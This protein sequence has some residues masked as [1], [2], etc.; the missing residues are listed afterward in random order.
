[1]C[2]ASLTESALVRRFFAA[3]DVEYEWDGEGASSS[4]AVS[5]PPDIGTV[6]FGPLTPDSKYTEQ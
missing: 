2:N 5:S 3:S 6:V 1:M 4:S